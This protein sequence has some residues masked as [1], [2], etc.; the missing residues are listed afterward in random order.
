[1]IGATREAQAFA[2]AKAQSVDKNF[3]ISVI[4]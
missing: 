1:M 3:T 2:F 4:S